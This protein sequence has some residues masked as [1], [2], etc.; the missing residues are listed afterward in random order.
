MQVIPTKIM[1]KII[2]RFGAKLVEPTKLIKWKISRFV[3]KWDMPTKQWIQRLGGQKE[4]SLY[5]T[6]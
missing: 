3:K 6:T 2:S 4:N 5:P 1:K